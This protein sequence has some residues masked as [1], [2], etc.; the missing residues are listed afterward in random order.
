LNAANTT[1]ITTVNTDISVTCA[2][3]PLVV[4]D[5]DVPCDVVTVV[6]AAVDG[7]V[8]GPVDAVDDAFELPAQTSRTIATT[9][10]TTIVSDFIIFGCNIS[11]W[12]CKL[13][14]DKLDTA[15]TTIQL[16]GGRVSTLTKSQWAYFFSRSS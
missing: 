7:V 1:H 9:T 5:G 11:S 2:E 8:V 15:T 4:L 12:A 13:R 14:E 3:D 10:T 6:T 16:I